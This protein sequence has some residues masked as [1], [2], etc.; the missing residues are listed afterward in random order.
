MPDEMGPQEGP[1][2]CRLTDMEK[3]SFDEEDRRIGAIRR[4]MSSHEGRVAA[5]TEENGTDTNAVE[6][7][8]DTPDEVEIVPDITHDTDVDQ[9]KSHATADSH[10][11]KKVKGRARKARSS[12]STGGIITALSIP[13]HQCEAGCRCT[14]AGQESRRDRDTPLTASGRLTTIKDAESPE[15]GFKRRQHRRPALH[16]TTLA[17]NNANGDAKQPH[18]DTLTG[19]HHYVQHRRLSTQDDTARGHLANYN[20]IT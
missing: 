17:N 5:I 16:S 3:I 19:P 13:P 20:A 6:T 9:S 15:E 12:E 4:G 2:S 7:P 14:H 10:E 11:W 18:K 1:S 8:S